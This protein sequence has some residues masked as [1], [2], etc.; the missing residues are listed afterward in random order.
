LTRAS[1]LISWFRHQIPDLAKFGVV[2]SVAFVI[3]DGGSNVLRFQAGLDPLTSNAIATIVA[4]IFAFCG[5]RYW[6]FRRRQRRGV[7][8]ES[9]LFFMFNGVGLLIQLTCIGFTSY[10]LGLTGRLSYNVALLV[11]ISLASLFRFWSYRKWV[12]LAPP[13]APAGSPRAKPRV[14]A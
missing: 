3:A 5:N 13:A 10:A 9:I 4:T 1:R 11:G 14:P 2:G 6:T 12:W 7:S 8:R